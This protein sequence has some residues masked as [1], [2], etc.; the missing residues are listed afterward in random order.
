MAKKLVEE[1]A[2]NS[3]LK[4]VEIHLNLMESKDIV[5]TT[6][7]TKEKLQKSLEVLKESLGMFINPETQLK[8][9]KKKRYQSYIQ[10]KD[11]FEEALK[12]G[13]KELIKK[14]E[15]EKNKCLD[16]YLKAKKISDELAR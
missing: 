3:I 2:L 9:I 10:A 16:D 15:D 4:A 13:D 5:V 1:K 12:S 11:K 7:D 6:G 8:Q 14:Y